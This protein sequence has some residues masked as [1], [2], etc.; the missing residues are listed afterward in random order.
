MPAIHTADDLIAHDGPVS[1]GQR[2]LWL[3][4]HYRGGHGRLN[5]PLLLRIRGELDPGA[6]QSAVDQ[7]VVRHEGLRTTF[8][9][10][11]GL[12]TAQVHHPSPVPIRLVRPASPSPDVL[13]QSIHEEI[14]TSIDPKSAPLRVTLWSPAATD[15][16]A[17]IN[18]HHLVTDAWSCRVLVDELAALL[19]GERN[20][21]RPGWQYRHFVHWQRRKTTLARQELD[22]EY[23]QRQL[24]GARG[25][26]LPWLAGAEPSSR[27]VNKTREVD[28]GTATWDRVR[29][30]ARSEQTTPFAV[31]LSIYY[32]ALYRESGDADLAVASP[33]ANRTRPEVMGTVGFFAN[34]LVLRCRIPREGTFLSLLRQ[35]RTTTAEALA[36]QGF[37]H[38]VPPAADGTGAGN[39][40]D[41]I[42]Q[43]LPGLPPPLTAGSLRIEVLPPVVASR[44]DLEMSVISRP[45]GLR[46]L[47]Q[48]APHR[49][50][51]PLADRLASSTS[52]MLR[53]L[54][55]DPQFRL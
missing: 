27:P 42:F 13:W 24:A 4:E 47:F 44:F 17:C 40:Q 50:E 43:M 30:L 52:E 3:I 21:P 18:A 19:G 1:V 20:L 26:A 48:Y 32:A 29:E 53:R 55:T 2:M 16:I 22:R 11:R 7:L 49:I 35:A 39:V 33:F 54:A 6:L 5:Y 28:V 15:H 14:H 36:H 10:R 34:L 41:I 23:W 12:L 9:R 51:D 46:V 8:V 37:T 38:F 25:P 45:G 31:L